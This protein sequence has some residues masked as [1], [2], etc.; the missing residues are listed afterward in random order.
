MSENQL[1]AGAAT[2]YIV[3]EK[4]EHKDG[5]PFISWLRQEGFEWFSFGHPNCLHALYINVNSKVYTW[6]M[7]GV[8]LSPIIFNHAI[9]IDEFKTIY[10]IFKKY[11]SLPIGYY[12]TPKEIK[13]DESV[14]QKI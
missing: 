12:S 5:D 3:D 6:G 9:H 8:Q 1:K 4:L 11:E 2:F 10:E 13:V 7:G 14:I